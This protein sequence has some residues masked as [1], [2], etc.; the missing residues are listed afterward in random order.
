MQWKLSVEEDAELRRL[1]ALAEFGALS[2]SQGRLITEL[3]RRDRRTNVRP[4]QDLILPLPRRPVEDGPRA[5][6]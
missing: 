5:T 2:E 6:A 1:A 3:R 4:V